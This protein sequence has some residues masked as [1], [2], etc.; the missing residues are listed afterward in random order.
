M[1]KQ[2]TGKR[3]VEHL[4]KLRLDSATRQ[5]RESEMRIIDIALENGFDSLRSFN[6]IFASEMG[7]N[8]SKYRR[9]QTS[10]RA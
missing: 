9:R 7:T 3:L 10:L 1:F 5:L 4:N 8:P 6:R 2:C